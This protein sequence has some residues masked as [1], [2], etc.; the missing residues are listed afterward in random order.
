MLYKPFCPGE[1]NDLL[2]RIEC[3]KY[4]FDVCFHTEKEGH[5]KQGQGQFLL[6]GIN[7]QTW[8]S[9]QGR[10]GKGINDL[11]SE[12]NICVHCPGTSGGLV[13]VYL[14]DDLRSETIQ[15]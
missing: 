13:A 4:L 1:P 10:T 5:R 2:E 14:T 15:R 12:E 3:L 7:F 11:N 8:F 9:A 6:F